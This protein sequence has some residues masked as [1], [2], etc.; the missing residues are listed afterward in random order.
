MILRG[1]RTS[2]Q[3]SEALHRLKIALGCSNRW[4]AVIGANVAPYVAFRDWELHLSDVSAGVGHWRVAYRHNGGC[5]HSCGDQRGRKELNHSGVSPIGAG[6][7]V[8][9]GHASRSFQQKFPH[10]S[11]TMREVE[12]VGDAVEDDSRIVNIIKA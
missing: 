3:G 8:R 5:E 2:S 4:P 9:D 7:P 12:A 1:R 11:S 10:A 6:L